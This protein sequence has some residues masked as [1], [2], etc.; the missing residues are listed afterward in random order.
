M[1]LKGLRLLLGA[2]ANVEFN[3]HIYAARRLAFEHGAF[4]RALDGF[5]VLQH[6][7]RAGEIIEFPLDLDLHAHRVAERL[8]ELARDHARALV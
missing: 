8:V 5:A 2:D 6:V 3:R 4:K 1:K 7:D